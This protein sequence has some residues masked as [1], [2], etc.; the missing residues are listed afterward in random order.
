[1]AGKRT[2]QPFYALS[3]K[4]AA[5]YQGGGPAGWALRNR[6]AEKAKRSAAALGRT[7]SVYYIAKGGGHVEIYRAVPG[8]F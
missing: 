4:E 1:M 6:F 7:V 2:H 8:E 5:I 3:M